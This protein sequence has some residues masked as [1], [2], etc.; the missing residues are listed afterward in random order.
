MLVFCIKE[1]RLNSI[2]ETEFSHLV[3][4]DK[5]IEII[6]GLPHLNLEHCNIMSCSCLNFESN[7]K[8]MVDSNI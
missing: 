8:L 5:I 4:E 7:I 2:S 3:R 6:K 1:E